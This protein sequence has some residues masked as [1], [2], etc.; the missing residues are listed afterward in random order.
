[1][2]N[3]ALTLFIKPDA[4]KNYSIGMISWKF[5]YR[6]KEHPA[7]IPADSWQDHIKKKSSQ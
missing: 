5:Q 7:D 4:S 6:K 2:L 1:M 3:N